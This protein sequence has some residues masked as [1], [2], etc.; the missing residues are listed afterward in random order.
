MGYN[1]LRLKQ[2]YPEICCSVLHPHCI[3]NIDVMATILEVEAEDAMEPNYEPTRTLQ[4]SRTPNPR[5]GF[6]PTLATI[7]EVEAE[8]AMEE[9]IFKDGKNSCHPNQGYHN[10]SRGTYCKF[11]YT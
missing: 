5:T 4:K 6:D 1:F 8:D 3:D 9:T 10:D 7:L 2:E 11:I